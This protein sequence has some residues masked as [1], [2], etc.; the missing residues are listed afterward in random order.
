M[1]DVGELGWDLGLNKVVRGIRGEWRM[2]NGEGGW[3]GFYGC[4][5]WMEKEERIRD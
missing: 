4:K 1:S 3:I 5:V 2:E